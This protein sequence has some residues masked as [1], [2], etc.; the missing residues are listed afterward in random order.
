ACEG[1]PLPFVIWESRRPDPSAPAD[2][3]DL[4][5]ARPRPFRRVG[6]RGGAGPPFPPPHFP[7]R[8]EPP[9]PPPPF[10]VPLRTPAR[11]R[12]PPA[13]REAAAGLFREVY[14]RHKGDPLFPNSF[15]K[16]TPVSMLL[17]EIP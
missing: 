16:L 13:P 12:P 8:Q 7:R 6:A 3:W 15:P 11:A 14:G 1:V 2:A 17:Q 5:R 10:L 4:W 9:A